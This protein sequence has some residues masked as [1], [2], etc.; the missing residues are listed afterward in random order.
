MV[1]GAAEWS[2]IASSTLIDDIADALVLTDTDDFVTA[3]TAAA[4]AKSGAIA[5]EAHNVKLIVTTT[6]LSLNSPIALT[7]NSYLVDI[8][9]YAGVLE[10]I[11]ANLNNVS[12][13]WNETKWIADAID[14]D[15]VMSWKGALPATID[16]ADPVSLKTLPCGIYLGSAANINFPV[17]ATCFVEVQRYDPVAAIIEITPVNSTA[18]ASKYC[19]LGSTT[20]APT[21]W[22]T[23]LKGDNAEN[24]LKSVGLNTSTVDPSVIIAGTNLNTIIGTGTMTSYYSCNVI[25]SSTLLNNPLSGYAFNLRVDRLAAA[26]GS[27]KQT[28]MTLNNAT[29]I[30]TYSRTTTDSGTTWTPWIIVEESY[31]GL[32]DT[33][34]TYFNAGGVASVA[35]VFPIGAVDA[36]G[37]NFELTAMSNQSV[38][39]YAVHAYTTLGLWHAT[40]LPKVV[41]M[42]PVSQPFTFRFGTKSTGELC[43]WV[44]GFIGIVDLAIRNAEFWN[45]N[46]ATI[47]EP[48]L[49]EANS[50][51]E[52]VTTTIEMIGDNTTIPTGAD[53]NTYWS[54]SWLERVTFVTANDTNA[55]SIINKP[56]LLTTNFKLIVEKYTVNSYKQTV[57]AYNSTEEWLRISNNGGTSWTAWQQVTTDSAAKQLLPSGDYASATFWPTV[58]AGKYM[59]RSDLCVG[60]NTPFGAML[61]NVIVDKGQVNTDTYVTWKTRTSDIATATVSV[62]GFSGWEISLH[63]GIISNAYNFEATTFNTNSTVRILTPWTGTDTIFCSFDVALVKGYYKADFS[64]TMFKNATGLVNFII[65]SGSA[66]VPMTIEAGIDSTGRVVFRVVTTDSGNGTC[67]VAITNLRAVNDTNNLAYKQ[68]WAVTSGGE[69][70]TITHTLQLYPSNFDTYSTTEQAVGAWTAGQLIYKKTVVLPGNI[71]LSADMWSILGP[72][73]TYIA[74]A[75]SI[76]KS[77]FILCPSVT[78][79][80][81]NGT[82][83]EAWSA[84]MSRIVENSS[85]TFWY[86][87]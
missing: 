78:R 68:G 13:Q 80:R 3:A 61:S 7:A 37:L 21:I 32:R 46:P 14:I 16:F 45:S 25:N 64:V 20:A 81:L 53:L 19:S 87:K 43:M 27:A 79:T 56:A 12:Y 18:I 44:S 11:K 34:A 52:N 47:H 15:S 39:K 28:L 48:W 83:I 24:V 59:Y 50:T 76:V 73:E 17:A 66:S 26:G 65:N 4:I 74:G 51:Y 77:E 72:V 29:I 63:N 22:K 1:A 55:Q 6:V 57:I 54:T 9:L 41:A 58:P 42:T 8:N 2:N 40:A 31:Q 82:N 70:T 84:G 30:K 5:T 69:L 86:L 71:P 35:V 36:T 33:P 67:S 62:N 75:T 10:N 49:I 85:V 23:V 60:P 38:S